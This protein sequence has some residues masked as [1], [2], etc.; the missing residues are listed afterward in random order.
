[1]VSAVTKYP[2]TQRNWKWMLFKNTS[3][4]RYCPQ[5]LWTAYHSRAIMRPFPPSPVFHPTPRQSTLN[6]WS[7]PLTAVL[8]TR[9]SQKFWF[10][11]TSVTVIKSMN[12]NEFL[13]AWG[14]GANKT[15][16]YGVEDSDLLQDSIFMLNMASSLLSCFKESIDDNVMWVCFLAVRSRKWFKRRSGDLWGK[17][18]APDNSGIQSEGPPGEF[19]EWQEGPSVCHPVPWFITLVTSVFEIIWS[20][21]GPQITLCVCVCRQGHST[22]PCP[23][24]PTISQQLIFAPRGVNLCTQSVACVRCPMGKSA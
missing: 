10:W 7:V 24:Q 1:M 22:A 11:T 20:G 17:V 9:A 12:W 13:N 18:L 19:G 8:P 6:N 21:A 14:G 5:S 3:R 15:K 23:N 4:L 2:M 16:H